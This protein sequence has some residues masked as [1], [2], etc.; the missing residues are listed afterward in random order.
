MKKRQDAAIAKFPQGI[1]LWVGWENQILLCPSRHSVSMHN[2]DPHNLLYIFTIGAKQT[3]Q[4]VKRVIK[5]DS[6]TSYVFW[7]HCDWQLTG[8]SLKP[9]LSD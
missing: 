7:L 9:S 4:Y 6:K 5:H 1:L 3:K 8:N 2:I